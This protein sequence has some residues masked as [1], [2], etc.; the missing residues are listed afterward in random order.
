M[1]VKKL[2]SIEM[3]WSENKM[4]GCPWIT[5]VMSRNRFKEIN[6]FLHVVNNA[7][8]IKRGQHGYN[9][10]LKIQPLIDYYSVPY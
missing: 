6:R 4:V 2:P 8:A 5:G 3:Y 7:E 10:L 1:G 9:P